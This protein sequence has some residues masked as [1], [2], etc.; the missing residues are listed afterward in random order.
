[1]VESGLLDDLKWLL[2]QRSG[3]SEED[4]EERPEKSFLE[5]LLG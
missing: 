5:E 3:D 1:M 4:E 2:G